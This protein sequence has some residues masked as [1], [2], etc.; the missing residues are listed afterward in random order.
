VLGGLIDENLR[1]GVSK[2]PLLGDLPL[3]GGLFR[4]R[5]DQ[6]SKRN[7]MVFLRP[8]ILR[9]AATSERLSMGKYNL[10]RNFQLEQR[11]REDMLLPSDVKPVL[12]AAPEGPAAAGGAGPQPEFTS[13]R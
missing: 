13:P 10:I 5:A 6:V 12:P 9:D 2:V 8:Q 3:L 4:Y 1:Q 7:L 11:E